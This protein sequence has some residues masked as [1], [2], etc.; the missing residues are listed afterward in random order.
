MLK[1]LRLTAAPFVILLALMSGC[2]IDQTQATSP[3]PTLT[4]SLSTAV[5]GEVAPTEETASPTVAPKDT[6]IV[7]K[8]LPRL[9]TTFEQ[10]DFEAKDAEAILTGTPRPSSPEPLAVLAGNAPPGTDVCN[11]PYSAITI[12]IYQ[13]CIH[14][15][16]S[17]VE[18]SNIIGWAGKE[19]SSSG[20]TVEYTWGD[21][22]GGVMSAV[23]QDNHLISK[24][25]VGL[26]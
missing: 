12:A 10:L 22:D 23:F 9:G 26:K 24:S 11:L 16:M 20:S 14:E 15:G 1:S 13:E 21:G 25:Q 19:A 4:P 2:S 17:Y 18:V 8:P 6:L 7:E 5:N 3:S